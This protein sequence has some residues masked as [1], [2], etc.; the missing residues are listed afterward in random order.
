MLGNGGGEESL[1]LRPCT[2]TITSLRATSG[3]LL[4]TTRLW[5]I[6]LSISSSL[7]RSVVTC[8]RLLEAD[9]GRVLVATVPSL[10]AAEART[11]LGGSVISRGVDVATGPLTAPAG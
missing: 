1:T 10:K 4:L 8:V 9:D 5:I 3:E 6:G 11:L 2:D 7:S